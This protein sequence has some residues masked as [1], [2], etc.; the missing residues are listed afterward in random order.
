MIWLIYIV[1]IRRSFITIFSMSVSLLQVINRT[2]L[3]T[4]SG[5]PAIYNS[6]RMVYFDVVL[7]KDSDSWVPM[8]YYVGSISVNSRAMMVFLLRSV[9]V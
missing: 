2:S 4:E 5:S 6:R 8:V 9:S 3:N 1:A 7:I